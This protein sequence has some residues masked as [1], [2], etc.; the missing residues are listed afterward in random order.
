[1][2]PQPVM[3]ST[4]GP[5]PIPPL[6][7]PS[8]S[9]ELASLRQHFA[10]TPFASF[11]LPVNTATLG[12]HESLVDRRSPLPLDNAFVQQTKDQIRVIVQSIASLANSIVEPRVFADNALTKV[13]QAM[14]A[15]GAGLWQRMPDSSWRL[16]SGVNLPQALVSDTTYELK[17]E[18]NRDP[19]VA[20]RLILDAVAGERQPILIPPGDVLLQRDRP[21]N[22]TSD[23]LMYAPLTT[24]E[25]QSDYWLQVVQ[26]PSGGPSS[27][28]GYLRFVAQMAD[29]FGDYFRTYRLRIFERDREYLTLAERTMDEL[30]TSVHVKRGLAQMMGSIRDHAQADH[31][32]LL[33]RTRRFGRWRVVAASGLID[34]DHRATGIEQIERIATQ[35]NTQLADGGTLQNQA[36]QLS[37]NDRDPDLSSFFLTFSVTHAGWTKPLRSHLSAQARTKPHTLPS[38]QDVAVLTLWSGASHPPSDI[39]QQSSLIVRL[40]LSALQIP[41]WKSALRESNEVAS[42]MPS[43]MN[44]T[45]W[46]R[47]AFWA[48][49]L[50]LTVLILSI[51]VPI[52]LHAT[53]VLVPAEQQHIY[54][55]WDAVVEKVFVDHGQEVKAGMPVLQLRSQSLQAEYDSILVQQTRNEQ[56]MSDIESKLLRETSLTSAQRDDLEGE[57][58]SL[59]AVQAVERKLVRRFQSQIDA[60]LI[61]AKLDGTVATWNVKSNLR[62]RPIR[63]GQWLM[64]IHQADS[65]W[66][67]EAVLPEH[68]AQELKESIAANNPD[69]VATMTGSPEQKV[70]IRF[71]QETLPRIDTVASGVPI[72]FDSHSNSVLRLRFDV[73]GATLPENVATAGATARVS[74]PNGTGPLAWALGK[75][76]VRR[77][78]TQIRLWI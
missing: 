71:N 8:P 18:S 4:S 65:K 19:S 78:I 11:P 24:N 45:T 3:T 41:W 72:E 29:L 57:R 28:R 56:R 66:M 49:G 50:I 15:I 75:D 32:F 9:D 1:M 30:S 20:H 59:A 21:T 77:A 63:T 38:K 76:F 73:D 74:I 17:H 52:R 51:P 31:A 23:L 35:L 62:D 58:K 27:Q 13:L 5:K 48:A 16:V 2:V 54:A 36:H 22:P 40:G 53:A 12:G 67:L 39:G 68:N 43:I 61:V 44:P 64:S 47:V 70:H 10:S 6:N 25:K 69:P 7:T 55:P 14:G 46:P 33:L 34:I 37:T 60:M 26:S 42:N